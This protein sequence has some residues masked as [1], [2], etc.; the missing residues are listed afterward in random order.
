MTVTLLKLAGQFAAALEKRNYTEAENAARTALSENRLGIMR[1]LTESDYPETVTV[2][3]NQTE[4]DRAAYKLA[5]L[6]WPSE[7]DDHRQRWYRRIVFE[8]D[9]L[10]AV[11][12]A[13]LAH[14]A[15]LKEVNTLTAEIRGDEFAGT[16]FQIVPAL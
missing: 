14:G 3:V 10:R 4:R 15:D 13:A 11:G 8:P 9:Q 16:D 1:M 2:R 12:M 6:A 5:C 7:A